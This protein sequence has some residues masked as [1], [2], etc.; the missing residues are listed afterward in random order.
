MLMLLLVATAIKTMKKGIK[1]Y[2]QETA[3]FE[4]QASL[5]SIKMEPTSNGYATL[6]ATAAAG[7]AKRDAANLKVNPDRQSA[8]AVL[9]WSPAEVKQWWERSLPPGCQ[10]YIHIVDECELDGADLLDLDF[11]SLSQFDVKKMLIMKILRRIK[12]LKQSL[13][14]REDAIP[15]KKPSAAAHDE[16]RSNDELDPIPEGGRDPRMVKAEQENNQLYMDI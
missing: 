14:I 4:R 1:K 8:K 3:S 10:E 5:A 15:V 7:E 12:Q 6:P 16:K 13:G 9:A 2:N 11:I